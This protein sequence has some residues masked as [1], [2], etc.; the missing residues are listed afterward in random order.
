[1]NIE[2]NVQKPHGDAIDD[3]TR[4]KNSF[5]L[6]FCN[7]FFL[8]L[9]SNWSC[10]VDFEFFKTDEILRSGEFLR[11]TCHQKLSVLSR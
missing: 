4:I 10:I 1:M 2:S 5:S 3:V 8:N 9:M 6:I 7:V 11:H